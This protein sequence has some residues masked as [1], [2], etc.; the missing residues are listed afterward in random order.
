MAASAPSVRPYGA[1]SSPITADLITAGQVGLSQ[2][3]VDGSDVYWL[4]SRADQGGRASL[5]RTEADGRR[6][7]KTP[8]QYVRATV[9]E[10]GGDA[11]D[12]AGGV[13]VFCSFADQILY[14]LD[15]DGEPVALTDGSM[16]YAAPRVYPDSD[17][18]LAI[19]EDHTQG[20]EAIASIVSLRLADG[21]ETVLVQ[22]ADFYDSVCLGPGGRIAWIEWDHPSMPWDTTCLRAGRLVGD[23]ITDVRTVL[24][25][26]DVSV[27]RPAWFPDGRLCFLSDESGFWNFAA[28]DGETIM[29]LHF[30]PCD[31]D[32]P[33]W[34][35]G[36]GTY[37]ILDDA[38]ILC[39]WFD[40]GIARLGIL[41]D[42]RLRRFGTDQV[43]VTALSASSDRAA[44]LLG[45]AD[46]PHT[47]VDVDLESG[48][49][50]AL[51]TAA[52]VEI[53]PAYV[54][55]AEP[56]T[57]GMPPVHAWYYAPTNPDH[58]APDG[59]LPPLRVVSHGGPTGMASSALRWEYQYWTSRGY[60]IVD[61]NYGGSTGYGREYR[62]RLKGAWPDT[63]D[64]LDFAYGSD[65]D[66]VS[67]DAGLDDEDDRERGPGRWGVVDVADCVAAARELAE[68]G[69][70]DPERIYIEGGSA[71]GYTTLQALTTTKV[72][73]AGISYYGIGDLAALA[74]DTHKFESRYLDSL[75]G[76]WPDEAERYAERSPIHHLDELSAPML[77]L[78]GTED[79]AVPPN[80]AEEMAAAVRAKG[81]PAGLILFEGEGHGFRRAE[82]IRRSLEASQWFLGEIFGFTP[83][84]P[85]EP[86]DL[87]KPGG[88]SAAT[89]SS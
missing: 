11:F 68:R 54:S 4:E 50:T 60:A 35:V 30:Q 88:H 2:V 10:Y 25:Q 38:R 79:R 77:L 47:I 33:P 61:V 6:T 27:I 66:P 28:Y 48:T 5:W 17:L 44:A 23:D 75:I 21:H 41:Q 13:I 83:A 52:A 14:R 9:H 22:G 12:V 84:D 20:G 43:T 73:A 67:D 87:G 1:W 72:F 76:V 65:D 19:R 69:L 82:T 78:Q 7:E 80:Q 71:G 58:R 86:V 81:L 15:P 42:G 18:V 24:Y 49:T 55:V 53:D 36:R 8:D 40:R 59:E 39:T 63:G 57:I 31:F 70:V 51:R 3:V 45:Y 16:R 74:R 34:Q 89:G 29:P 64:A 26:E 56:I 46:R 32:S 62:E 85:V 37:A